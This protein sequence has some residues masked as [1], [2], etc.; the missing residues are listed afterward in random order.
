MINKRILL[1]YTGGT[2][3]MVK[4]KLK[5]T[6][7]PFDFDFAGLVDAPYVKLRPEHKLTSSKD[8]IFL[9]FRDDASDLKS[10]KRYFKHKQDPII[11]TIK[12]CTLLSKRNKRERNR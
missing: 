8:R 9:G 3:G 1:I 5:K 7:V 2:I 10:A 11:K 12:D 4:D 6:L